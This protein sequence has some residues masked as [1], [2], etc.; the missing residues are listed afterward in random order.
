MR[1]A[2][3]LLKLLAAAGLALL[4]AACATGPKITAET[5]A[6][7]DFSGYRTFA[8]YSPLAM[9]RDGYATPST[10]R[11][12]AA[13]RREMEARGYVYDAAN[14]DL[15]VNIN[16]YIVERTDVTT[17]PEVNYGW[18]YSYRSQAYVGF[19]VFT[20]RTDVREYREGTMNVDLVDVDQK[21]L[22]WEGMAVGRV[23]KLPADKRAERIDATIGQI[24]AQFPHRAQ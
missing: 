4:L 3:P 5:V 16:A 1:H 11:A 19:P 9:E 15:W 6:G 8:F 13:A 24:F 14:P 17:I 23:A 12:V 10:E 21:R 22:V 2:R 20:E 7:A 18:Y